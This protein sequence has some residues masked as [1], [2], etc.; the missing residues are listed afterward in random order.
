[1][2]KI[3]VIIGI[4]LTSSKLLYAQENNVYA[5]YDTLL[6]DLKVKSFAPYTSSRTLK[7]FNIKDQNDYLYD[8]KDTLNQE[9]KQFF[10][11]IDTSKIESGQVD[12]LFSMK[13]PE[14]S[15]TQRGVIFSPVLIS[16]EG[17]K[18]MCG[19]HLDW[20]GDYMFLLEK[21]DGKWII[22][23]RYIMSME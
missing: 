9:W 5:I 1:M 8:R 12:S 20:S 16:P 2:K 13:H 7:E 14:N 19:L 23:K 4:L 6:K 22:R 21:K 10:H 15:K 17:S 18:A 11:S 3:I